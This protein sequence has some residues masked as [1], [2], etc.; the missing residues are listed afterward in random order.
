MAKSL[1][2]AVIESIA[3]TQEVSMSEASRQYVKNSERVV[4]LDDLPRV[5]HNWTDRGL[6]QTCENAGHPY[7]EAWKVR[8]LMTKA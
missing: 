4:R 5:T 3:E 2:D 7:H 8:K 1:V 6:K